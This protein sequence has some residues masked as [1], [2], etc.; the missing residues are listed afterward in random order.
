MDSVLAQTF[1]AK[2]IIVVDD[3]STDETG[4]VLQGYGKK[5]QVITLGS[6]GGVSKTRNTGIQKASCEWIALLDSDDKWAPEK[7][8]KDREFMILNPSFQFLQ[9]IEIWYRNGVRVNPKKYHQQPEGSIF[10]KCLER[11]LVSPSSVVLHR[12]FF[13]RFGYFDEQLPACEDYDFWLRLTRYLPCGLNKH[14]TV[15]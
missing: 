11:C 15:I 14:P 4:N 1:S 10:E 13:E 6:N 12:S 8:E 5:I 3:S 9:S 7:L 2:E